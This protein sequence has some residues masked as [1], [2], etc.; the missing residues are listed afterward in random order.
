MTQ[1]CKNGQMLLLDSDRRAK[2]PTPEDVLS[3]WH[4]AVG[5]LQS[6]AGTG[7][8]CRQQ[9]AEQDGDRVVAGSAPEGGAV[10]TAALLQAASEEALSG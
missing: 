1:P 3:A 10:I 7:A 2:G 5:G 6:K 8:A 4:R 9:S